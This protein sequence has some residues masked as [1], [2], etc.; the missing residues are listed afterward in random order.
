MGQIPE[1]AIEE[2]HGH[3]GVMDDLAELLALTLDRLL[4]SLALG[5]VTSHG[6]EAHDPLALVNELHVLAEPDVLAQPRH[7]GELAVGVGNELAHL[8][9]VEALGLLAV[10][11]ADGLRV[12]AAQE[13]R[14]GESEGRQRGRVR[15]G[16]AA[17]DVELV[18]DVVRRLHELTV[19][20]LAVAQ[21]VPLGAHLVALDP[22][23]VT[24]G[25]ESG[26]LRGR[27]RSFAR[28]PREPPA[29]V[30]APGQE[31]EGGERQDDADG[32]R[33]AQ[34]GPPPEQYLRVGGGSR[35]GQP[36]STTT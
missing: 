7:R 24:R 5:D 6:L 30:E 32:D 17:L 15:V 35:S 26:P 14:L 8:V 22:G 33:S 25:L 28:A 13:L 1:V 4:G 31:G 12:V 27:G 29:K 10:V 23:L 9:V 21:A 11:L 16:E 3:G 18:D 36:S 2:S 34:E 19:A 20:G